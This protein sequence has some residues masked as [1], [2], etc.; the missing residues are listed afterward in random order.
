MKS[1]ARDEIMRCIGMARARYRIGMRN[2]V[3]DLSRYIH[4]VGAR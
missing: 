3:Y 1:R 4:L 2:L